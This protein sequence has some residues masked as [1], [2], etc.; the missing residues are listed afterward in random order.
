MTRLKA[1]TPALL[2]SCICAG[3]LAL[4]GAGVGPAAPAR[5]SS[6]SASVI[7]EMG[8]SSPRAALQHLVN[9]VATG[10]F[11]TGAQACATTSMAQHF[12]WTALEHLEGSWSTDF[13]V[14]PA[15]YGYW[16]QANA[17]LFLDRCVSSMRSLAMRLIAPH[18][19]GTLGGVYT[20]NPQKLSA[21]LNPAAISGLHVVRFDDV[22]FAGAA[23]RSKQQE[24][25]W[26]GGQACVSD[27]ALLQLGS[28]Y[29]L[30]GPSFIE[31]DGS[32]HIAWVTGDAASLAGVGVDGT[33]PVSESGYLAE[34]ARIRHVATLAG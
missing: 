12:N 25:G 34:L 10:A 6:V 2:I 17:E 32:W 15:Q 11:F 14:L 23:L 22:R 4:S 3:A 1:L 18:G 9:G 20:G 7:P 28:S 26:A 8:F 21:E 30:V 13:S 33:M 27:L 19:L 31:Y 29:W 16:Q 5:A 24:C